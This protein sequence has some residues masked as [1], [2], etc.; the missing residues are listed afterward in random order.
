MFL[1]VSRRQA[2]V[3]WFHMHSFTVNLSSRLNQLSNPSL[4]NCEWYNHFISTSLLT[5][6]H[7]NIH[8]ICHFFKSSKFR[9]LRFYAKP[10]TKRVH[11]YWEI[12][13]KNFFMTPLLVANA[14]PKNWSTDEY[15]YKEFFS[16]FNI[17]VNFR[18]YWNFINLTV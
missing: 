8:V 18:I 12:T 10:I 1:S 15:S 16:P 17:T 14:H 13:I 11:E 3:T 2:S 9:S 5:Y 6:K 4:C 7:K